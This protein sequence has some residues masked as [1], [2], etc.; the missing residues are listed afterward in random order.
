MDEKILRIIDANFNRAREGLRVCEEVVRFCLD[1]DAFT[2]RLKEARHELTSILKSLPVERG[3]LLDSRDTQ[4]DVGR[5]ID[6][7]KI[8]RKGL[9]EIFEANVQRVK[10]S[11]RVLE[12]FGRA[13][14]ADLAQACKDLRFR[15]YEIEKE[16]SGE[17]ESLSD[18]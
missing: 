6:E 16:I 3:K 17:L 11:L 10:E 13:V 12:E 1:D 2:G 14:D 15:I 4:S 7:G 9:R 8:S 18:T 5:D